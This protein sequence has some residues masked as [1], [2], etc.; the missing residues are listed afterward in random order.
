M[1]TIKANSILMINRT[2]MRSGKEGKRFLSGYGELIAK[3]QR[4]IGYSIYSSLSILLDCGY[5]LTYLRVMLRN[6]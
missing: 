2:N 5:V 6:T 4:N 3:R 1:P